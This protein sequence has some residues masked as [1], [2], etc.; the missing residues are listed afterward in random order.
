[1]RY[2][3]IESINKDLFEERVRTFLD[4]G[5]SLSGGVS[6]SCDPKFGCLVYYQ[7][8]TK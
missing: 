2:Y 1:M 5:Y 6:I 8:V 7:A 4:Q 3:I